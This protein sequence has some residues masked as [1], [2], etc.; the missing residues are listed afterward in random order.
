M[1]LEGEEAEKTMNNRWD[2]IDRRGRKVGCVFF[3]QSIKQY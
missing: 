3:E 1:C 2:K